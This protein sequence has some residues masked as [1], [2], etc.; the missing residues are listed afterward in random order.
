[1]IWTESQAFNIIGDTIIFNNK[2]KTESNT[3]KRGK[4]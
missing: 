4:S 1:M 2:K 3:T